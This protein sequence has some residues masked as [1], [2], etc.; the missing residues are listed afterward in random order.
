MVE[1]QKSCPA[2]VKLRL[3][4]YE[5]DIPQN[6]GTLFRLAAC[7]GIP[8]DLIEP[9][10]FDASD[11][12]LRRAGLDYLNFVHIERHLSFAHFEAWRR[13]RGHRLVLATTH[14]A[15]NAYAFAFQPGDIVM[16]GRESAGAPPA[17]HEAADSRIALPL[18]P[19]LRSLNIAV[20]GAMLVGEALRQLDALPAFGSTQASQKP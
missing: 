13:E 14:G 9:A 15:Q 16:L 18:A 2:P 3:A 4:L 11:R 19:G 1:V 17:V 6:A 8:V 7:M 20:A 5:P 12:N 10:G